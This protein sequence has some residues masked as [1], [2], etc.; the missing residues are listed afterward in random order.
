MLGLNQSLTFYK[1]LFFTNPKIFQHILS[2]AY[3]KALYLLANIN[4]IFLGANIDN[5]NKLFVTEDVVIATV[6]AS[7]MKKMPLFN[8]FSIW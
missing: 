5:N 3:P 4:V 1:N 7:I 8:N 6:A 2:I